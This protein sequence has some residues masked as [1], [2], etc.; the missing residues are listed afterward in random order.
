LEAA[1]NWIGLIAETVIRLF[2]H[3]KI[4]TVTQG[5]IKMRRGHEISVLGPGLHWY[6]PTITVINVVTTVRDT[7][8]L[9]G[10]TFT[11]KDGKVVLA[12]G[13]VMYSVNDVEK[14]LTSSPDYVSTISDVCMNCIHDCFIKYEWEQ[15]RAGILDGTIG[16]EL[17]KAASEELRPF[18][19]KIIS[20]GLKDLAPVR[21]MKIVQDV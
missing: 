14:L 2:P 17:K 4:V 11:T 21:V 9:A 12:S 5:G 10:Q 8:D 3:L 1:L 13:M 19:I 18:G 20:L 6:W 7:Q 15:L 16:K